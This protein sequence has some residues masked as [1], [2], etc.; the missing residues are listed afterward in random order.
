MIEVLT[1]ERPD[2]IEAVR[3]LILSHAESLREH[4]GSDQVRRDA[5][6]LPGPYVPPRGRLF[7]AKLDRMPAGCVAL[8]P[9]EPFIAEVKR[10]Y[11][12]TTARRMGVARALMQ[13]LLADARHMGYHRVRLGTL[14][15]MTAAQALYRELGFVEIPRYR[16]DEMVDTLFFEC[17]LTGQR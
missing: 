9:L 11:V 7:L 5:E 13:Q 4:P 8:K 16:P 12:L 3:F 15:E 2:E 14:D 17:N 6:S 10:M 1:A